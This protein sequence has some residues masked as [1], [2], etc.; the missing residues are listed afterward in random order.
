LNFYSIRSKYSSF[1][2]AISWL[3]SDRI[4]FFSNFLYCHLIFIDKGNNY[5]ST[6]C[7][8]SFLNYSYIAIDYSDFNHRITRNFDY[9]IFSR[10]NHAR[11][12]VNKFSQ[13]SKC[14]YGHACRNPPVEW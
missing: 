6:F 7:A 8:I 12:H 10:R 9:I 4:A 1:I 14:L 13:I 5:F 2:G 3:K 11:W